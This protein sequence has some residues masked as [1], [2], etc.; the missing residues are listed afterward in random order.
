MDGATASPSNAHKTL[1]LQLIRSRLI[2]LEDTIIFRLIERSQYP[3]NKHIY[4]P[5][6]IAIPNSNLSLLDFLLQEQERLHSQLGRFESQD[7]CPFFPDAVRNPILHPPEYPSILHENDVNINH[8]LK[9]RYINTIVPLICGQ[10]DCLPG[11]VDT[12]PGSTATCDIACLQSLSQRIHLG[13]FSAEAIFQSEPTTFIDLI[14]RRDLRGLSAALD[15]RCMEDGVVERLRLKATTYGT[16]SVVPAAHCRKI[17]ADAVS[18]L[19]WGLVFPLVRRVE[20]EYL[21]QR[22]R[23]TEWES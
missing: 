22:L 8:D 12:N 19:Y 11:L 14:R 5:G 9:L 1:D 23:G 4:I 15:Q 6:A 21:M 17:A 16:V 2:R 20:V 18:T 7:Q 13:K 10:K 3:L